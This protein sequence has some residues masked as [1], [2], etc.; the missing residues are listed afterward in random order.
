[1]KNLIRITFLSLLTINAFSNQVRAQ[2]QEYSQE[3]TIP[4]IAEQEHSAVIKVK[5]NAFNIRSKDNVYSFSLKL[6]FFE[7]DST[8]P[9]SDDHKISLMSIDKSK[10]PV[11]GLIPS[12]INQDGIGIIRWDSPRPVS[13]VLIK[14]RTGDLVENG[15][16]KGVHKIIYPKQKLPHIIDASDDKDSLKMRIPVEMEIPLE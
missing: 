15:Y 4:Q 7:G 12:R 10:Y 11:W 3:I 1:M 16:L 5:S 13:E 9:A 6:K 8:S 14:T 2:E